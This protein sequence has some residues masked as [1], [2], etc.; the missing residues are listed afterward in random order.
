MKT[1]KDF[2]AEAERI[3]KL[4]IAERTV[5]AREY[6]AIAYRSNPRFQWQTFAKACQLP[7]ESK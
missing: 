5:A 7:K 4:P 3:A 6:A 2:R 1:R